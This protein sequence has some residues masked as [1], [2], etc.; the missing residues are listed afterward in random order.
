MNYLQNKKQTS[1]SK[2]NGTQHYFNLP[3]IFFDSPGR[4]LKPHTVH[5]WHYFR[6]KRSRG[7]ADNEA[8]KS[9]ARAVE[10]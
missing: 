4:K 8:C 5:I 2:R 1:N 3:S 9:R 10:P 6:T 7:L